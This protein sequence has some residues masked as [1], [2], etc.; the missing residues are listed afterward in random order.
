MLEGYALHE[1]VFDQAGRMVDFKYLEF[2]PVAQEIV[3]IPRDKIVGKTAL[4]LF[5]NLVERGL[6]DKYADVMATGKSAYI[7][8]FYYEGDT[9]N[10]AFDISCF[11]L[12]EKHFVCIFRDITNSKRSEQ[13]R[14]ILLGNLSEKTSEMENLLRIVTHD[15]RVPLVN[16]QGFGHELEADCK[17]MT[18]TLNE[19]D[20][21]KQVEK[22]ISA[23][24]DEDIPQSI[25]F[26][27]TS[28]KK[29]NSLIEG[30]N[31]LSK[32]EKVDL[33]IETLDM[34]EVIQQVT[35]TLHFRVDELGASMN[36]ESLP[37]CKADANQINQVF[38]NLIDNSLKYLDPVRK[39]QITITGQAKEDKSIYCVE[40]NGIGIPQKHI[41]KVFALFHQVDGKSEAGGEG[42][43][44]ATVKQM[45]SRNNGRIWVESEEGKGSKFFVSLP[46]G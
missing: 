7:E 45:L 19:V 32:A 10:K 1:A 17:L 22:E 18:K 27:S 6:M 41:D 16:I 29:M 44:L 9:V 15:L 14:E 23:L 33:N 46:N 20:L 28:V 21:D 25:N 8:D 30:L 12:D 3:N 5:P 24:I 35:E 40:D 43:G 26:I 36:I 39:G 37:D 2:N 13:E 42:V 11:C 4:Q 34:N 31:Q 38:S